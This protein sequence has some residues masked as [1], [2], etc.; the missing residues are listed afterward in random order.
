MRECSCHS[1]NG[2]RLSPEGL[3]QREPKV[4]AFPEGGLTD[5]DS[6]VRLDIEVSVSGLRRD[7]THWVHEVI[8][9][10]YQRFLNGS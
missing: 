1:H 8:E 4:D 2:F 6:L 7:E 9:E 10:Q 5:D 3:A